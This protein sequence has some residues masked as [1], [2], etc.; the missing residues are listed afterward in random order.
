MFRNRPL[1]YWECDST[2]FDPVLVCPDG[3]PPVRVTLMYKRDLVSGRAAF[4]VESEKKATKRWPFPSPW[5][6]RGR[7]GLAQRGK[8]W[9]KP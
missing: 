2:C 8:W 3:P 5:K 1:R 7:K 4:W 6:R 9:C